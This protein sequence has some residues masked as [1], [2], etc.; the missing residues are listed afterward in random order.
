[1]PQIFIV[2]IIMICNQVTM[3]TVGYGD[4][5]PKTWAGIVVGSLCALSGVT[6][7]FQSSLSLFH[8]AG[9]VFRS[10][11]AQP[12]ETFTFQSSLSRLN[13]HFQF[14]TLCLSLHVTCQMSQYGICKKNF[15]QHCYWL[16]LCA[17]SL[18]Y[19]PH[20]ILASFV[21]TALLT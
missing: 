3:T 5:V 4:M 2:I 19:S 14:F 20:F 13:C 9:I 10:L 21:F 8:L 16:P 15:V 17:P 1:M 7:T 12:G 6:F 18:G 11:C